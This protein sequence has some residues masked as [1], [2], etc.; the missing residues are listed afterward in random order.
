[1]IAIDAANYEFKQYGGGVFN[2]SD[3]STRLNHAMLAVG[4]GSDGG[5]EYWLAKNSWGA[6]WGE[7]G[8]VRIQITEG[9]GICG[10]Q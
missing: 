6:Y 2:L 7:S 10:C 3:C 5:I 9:K 1:M 8:Y 4:Y